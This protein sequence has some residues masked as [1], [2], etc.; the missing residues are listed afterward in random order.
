MASGVSNPLTSVGIA[1]SRRSDSLTSVGTASAPCLAMLT[2]HLGLSSWTHRSEPARSTK[3]SFPFVTF[4]VCR[5]VDSMTM[6]MIRCDRDDSRFICG[7]T[8]Q[9]LSA[10]P[11]G[12]DAMHAVRKSA[13]RQDCSYALQCLDTLA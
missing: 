2:L 10:L 13:P 5:F 6:L 8:V 7:H 9:A 4:W 3:L 12:V 1:E 11:L